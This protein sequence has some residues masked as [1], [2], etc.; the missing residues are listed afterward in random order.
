MHKAVLLQLAATL[1]AAAIASALFG[2][3]GL[4]SAMCGA[5]AYVAPSVFFTWRLWL[6]SLREGH[7]KVTAFM[8]GEFVKLLSTLGL[9]ALAVVLYKNLHWGS[10]LIGLVL[11]VKANLFAFL[12]KTRT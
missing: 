10:F 6:A 1:I 11:V 4:F 9:L 2:V 8:A 3:R 12:V 7:A 5:L